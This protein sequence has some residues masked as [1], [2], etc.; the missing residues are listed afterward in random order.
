VLYY[1]SRW[2]LRRPSIRSLLIDCPFYHMG[3]VKVW[4]R[5]CQAN[6]LKHVLLSKFIKIIKINNGHPTPGIRTADAE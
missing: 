2:I 3:V 1:D 4:V 6:D 5:L